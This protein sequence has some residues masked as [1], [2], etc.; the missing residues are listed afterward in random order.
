M[1]ALRDLNEDAAEAYVSSLHCTVSFLTD[2]TTLNLIKDFASGGVISENDLYNL[3]IGQ[4]LLASWRLMKE[5]GPFDVENP[6][7][8][9]EFQARHYFYTGGDDV[10]HHLK[11]KNIVPTHLKQG[12]LNLL[13]RGEEID[14]VPKRIGEWA[15]KVPRALARL[16][17][18]EETVHVLHSEL[19]LPPFRALLVARL[20]CIAEPHLFDLDRLEIGVGAEFRFVVFGR[21]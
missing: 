12:V 19:S 18:G 20:L 4:T 11:A 13:G 10:P 21:R 16:R 3:T 9:D 14:T 2:T 8:V 7:S 5:Y 6:M 17:S 15:A 1:S